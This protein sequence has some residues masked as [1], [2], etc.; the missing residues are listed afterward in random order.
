MKIKLSKSQWEA[1]GRKAGWKKAY[2]VIP[3]DGLA[4]GGTPYTSEEMDF[5]EKEDKSKEE[6]NRIKEEISKIVD[7]WN[8]NLLSKEGLEARLKEIIEKMYKAKGIHPD[9]KV[10]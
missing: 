5:M 2:S 4:D 1:I 8:Q 7:E 9:L 10:E 3:S 6:V